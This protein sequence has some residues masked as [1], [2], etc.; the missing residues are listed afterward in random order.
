MFWYALGSDPPPFPPQSRQ[1]GQLSVPHHVQKR[2][3]C[4]QVQHGP[5]DDVQDGQQA[6][7]AAGGQDGREPDQPPPQQ[8]ATGVVQQSTQSCKEAEEQEALRRSRGGH[9]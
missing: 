7:V 8:L 1:A 5:Q 6:G 4:T 2:S 3:R 9:D